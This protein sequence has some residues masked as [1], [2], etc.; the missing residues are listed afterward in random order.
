MTI[1]TGTIHVEHLWKRFKADR[2]KPQIRD[3][4]ARAR[5]GTRSKG[6]GWR[7]ALRDVQLA[8]EPGSSVGLFG[9]NGSGKSTLLKIL[10]GVMYP[11]AG[12]VEVSG[13]IGALIEVSSGMHPEL[14][15]RE[16][17]YLFGSLLGLRREAVARQFDE[18]VSFAEVETAIDRQL[19]FY[20]SGMKMRLGFAVA[21]FLQPDVMLVDEVLAVGDA[22]FQ[23]KCIDRMRVV[24]NDGITL[25]FVSHDLAAIEATCA[26]GVWLNAGVVQADAPVQEALAAYRRWIEEAAETAQVA[27]GPLKLLKVEVAGVDGQPARTQEP[28]EIR[29]LLESEGPEN[30]LLF[31][32]VTEG[33][34]SPVFLVT[35]GIS[36]EQGE[37]EIRATIANLPLP[38]G[39]FYLWMGVLCKRRGQVIPWQPVTRFEVEGGVL[40]EG[41]RG[42]V[43][44]APV[45]VTVGW[46]SEP[47]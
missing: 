15:G 19:K 23:Q 25:V 36:L 17:T 12:H 11:Y 9:G 37:T 10:S 27:G 46:E 30:G 26:R 28:L 22:S 38:R 13:R 42:V 1:R 39:R 43:R 35:R 44:L 18:I 5:S 2:S 3:K 31:T 21:A 47:H 33:T 20:S 29:F 4:L 6:P 24:L 45:H 34:A 40:D 7:W 41:P 32:G 8:V 14:T 16:N